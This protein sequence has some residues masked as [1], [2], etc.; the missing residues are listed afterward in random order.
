MARSHD[1][2]G[3]G[4]PGRQSHIRNR[5]RQKIAVIIANPQAERADD[6]HPFSIRRPF[7]SLGNA[8]R[9]QQADDDGDEILPFFHRNAP[10]MVHRGA[11][12]RRWLSIAAASS[13]SDDQKSLTPAAVATGAEGGCVSTAARPIDGLA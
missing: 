6:R 11:W 1:A 4:E 12:G 13:R 3:I 10:S 9:D 7:E 2:L 5:S 8:S